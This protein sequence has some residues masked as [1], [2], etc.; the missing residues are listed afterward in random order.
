MTARLSVFELE[1]K[2]LLIREDI[3]EMLTKAG[4]GHAAG[5]LGM[6]DIFAALYFSVLKHDPQHPDWSERDKLLLSN[7]HICPVLYATL[8]HAGYF[9]RSK[10]WT[11]RKLGSPLQ[12]H[13]SRLALPGL[14][15]SGGPLGQ[16]LSQAI[17]MALAAKMDGKTSQVYCVMSDGEHDEGQ[18]WEAI[19]FAGKKRIANL[20]AIIDRNNI[21]IDG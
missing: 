13:P 12:G 9:S 18:T 11:L 8:A 5:A 21:Q 17:G 16:G 15:N 4:S 2:A 1:Q 6:A 7:G 10:L 3:V 14:E 19:L 20:T